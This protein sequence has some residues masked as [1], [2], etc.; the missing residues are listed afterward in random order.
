MSHLIRYTREWCIMAT[1]PDSVPS[2]TARGV[3]REVVCR[4]EVS[5]ELVP[6]VLELLV[7]WRLLDLGERGMPDASIWRLV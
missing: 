1:K 3:I 4:Y 5:S 2:A 7:D 6:L